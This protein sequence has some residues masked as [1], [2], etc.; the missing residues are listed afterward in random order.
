MSAIAIFCIVILFN[1]LIDPFGIFNLIELDG[2]NKDKISVQK[3]A[4]LNRAANIAILKPKAIIIGS[5]RMVSMDPEYLKVLVND[6]AV[7]NSAI[8]G[9]NFEEIYAYFLHAA[10]VQPDLKHVLIGIDL[11]AFNENKKSGKDFSFDRL[12]RLSLP[13]DDKFKSLLCY[14]ALKDSFATLAHNLL[15]KQ[16]V[17]NQEIIQFG[18][19]N[20]LKETLITDANYKNYKIS[21]DRIQK[22][23]HMVKICEDRNI[24]LK[25][26]ISPVKAYYWEFYHRYNLWPFVEEL[27]IELSQLHSLWDF[28]GYNEVTVETLDIQ[29]GSKLYYECSHF[30]P[31]TA[32]ILMDR[33]FDRPALCEV[34]RLLTKGNFDAVSRAIEEERVEWLKKNG[35]MMNELVKAIDDSKGMRP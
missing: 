35:K 25:V 22:F 7:Y 31:F 3:H 12:Q 14:A 28:S 26:F 2:V 8:Q 33:M 20:Y 10:Y 29:E 15:R 6:D 23:K 16:E 24:D 18:E 19:P 1:L 9:A 30:T 5:S 27:K 17:E 11:F 21:Q 4:R 32:R 34:G 13:I